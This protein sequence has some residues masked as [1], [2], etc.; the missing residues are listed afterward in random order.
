MS[1]LD[2]NGNVDFSNLPRYTRRAKSNAIDVRRVV[3]KSPKVVKV[4][5]H[6]VSSGGIGAGNASEPS[7]WQ[8]IADLTG[9]DTCDEGVEIIVHVN[10]Q[11]GNFNVKPAVRIKAVGGATGAY[12]SENLNESFLVSAL[13]SSQ[14]LQSGEKSQSIF[15]PTT[16]LRRIQITNVD[17]DSLTTQQFAAIAANFASHL[18]FRIT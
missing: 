10:E 11:F 5:V 6:N 9:I 13:G 16:D 17:D 18:E 12:S 14:T 3:S 8:T 7:T 15:I 2:S 1:D 4:L